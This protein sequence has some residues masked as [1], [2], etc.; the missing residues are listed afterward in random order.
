MFVFCAVAF[1][2]FVFALCL[3]RCVSSCVRLL[4]PFFVFAVCLAFV[5]VSCLL[6]AFAVFVFLVCARD[7]SM[8]FPKFPGCV[9]QL[10]L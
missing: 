6:V 9:Q 2:V 8:R 1:V 5:L 3:R 4:C 7:E 10:C